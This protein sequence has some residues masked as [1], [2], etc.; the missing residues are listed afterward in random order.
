MATESKRRSIWSGALSFGLV[1]VPVR[2]FT[3]IV[4]HDIHFHEYQGGTGQRI[5]HKRV[6]EKSGREVPYQQIV[7]GYEVGRGKVI[8]L[9]PEEIESIEPRKSKTI[10]IE[11]FVELASIDPIVWDATY[12]I[13]PGDNAG[14]GK[15][16][17]LL[18]RAME[19]TGRVG[20]GRFVMR[21]KEYLVTVR[22]LGS[23]LVL[24]T[25]HYPDEIR[26]QSEAGAVAPRVAVAPRELAL[27]RQLIDS[28]SE[29]W[30]HGKFKD[31]Y[32]DQMEALIAKKAKGQKIEIEEAPEEEGQVVD[33]MEALK[34]SLGG[35]RGVKS[36]KRTAKPAAGNGERRRGGSARG[37][38]ARGKEPRRKAK[39]GRRRAA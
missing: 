28:L 2:L 17:A 38:Q 12:Y 29:D 25:M 37:A 34:A 14:A 22:P 19:D 36:G 11:Q 4:S 39:S 10:E 21:T 13:G 23:G 24:E 8:T 7:K 3:A 15:S 32:R 33:L 6:A 18:L 35:G 9:E 16:Y 20:I 5:H 26:S 1:N 31:T 30:N 27:A